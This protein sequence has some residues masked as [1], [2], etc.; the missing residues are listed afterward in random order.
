[1]PSVRLTTTFLSFILLNQPSLVPFQA[2][3]GKAS[4][5]PDF[6]LAGG[7]DYNVERAGLTMGLTLGLDLPATFSPP[8]GAT[9]PEL[10]GNTMGSLCSSSTLVVRGEGDYSILPVGKSAV[11]V[12]AAKLIAREDFL[13]FFSVLLDLYYTR[14]A[15]QTRLTKGMSGEQLRD[16]SR[17]DQ[18][19][20]NLSLQARF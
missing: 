20:F 17:P 5:T 15:N 4:I 18:L 19:G 10:C 14:D 3:P 7:F 12:F 16:F 11:P 2:F 6:F 9:L 1:M 13:E 8:S